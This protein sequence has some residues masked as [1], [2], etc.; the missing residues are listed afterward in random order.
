MLRK[1][2][3]YP[4][5]IV[6]YTP[7]IKIKSN[8][9]FLKITVYL[10]KMSITLSKLSTLNKISTLTTSISFGPIMLFCPIF[11]VL[12]GYIYTFNR[13]LSPR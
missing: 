13:M 7:Y 5:S 3:I 9:K 10:K 4:I 1:Q 12:F 6:D 2:S 11:G 8:T